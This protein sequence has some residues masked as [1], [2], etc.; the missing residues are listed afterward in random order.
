[1]PLLLFRALI[2]CLACS[3]ILAAQEQ[4]N[5]AVAGKPRPRLGVAL[6]GGNALGLAHIGILRYFEE[7]HIPIDYIT[8]TSMGGLVGG[9]YA[10]GLDAAQLE[11]IVR[12]ANWDDLLSANYRF[13]DEPIV[14]KQEWNRQAGWLTLRFGKRF[15]LPA[16]INPGQALALLLSRHTQAYSN[17][18]TF[19]DLPTPFRC[20]ATDLVTG[21]PFVL[22]RGS[23]PKA[24][25]ATMALPGI[26]TPVNW[27]DKVL[28]DGGITNNLP[29]DE[30][31]KMGADKVIAVVV[32]TGQPSARQFTS[33]TTVLRQTASIAVL[34]NERQQAANAN[35]VIR[36]QLAG[37]TGADYEQSGKIIQQGYLAA[38]AM[39]EQLEPY[40]MHSDAEWEA[41]LAARKQRFQIAP[42]QGPLVAVASPQPAIERNATHELYRKL[43]AAP[44]AEGQLEDVL[45]GVVAATGLPGAYYEWLSDPGQRQGYRVE[46]LERPDQMLLMHPALS[47]SISSGEPGRAAL[48]LGA[49]V[50]P[51]STY[52]SRYLAEF[53]VGYDPGFR[54]E[55]YHPFDGSGYFIA[56]GLMVQ[57]WH[58]SQYQ[59]PIHQTFIRD[60][61]AGSFYAGLGTWRF[62]QFRVGVRAGYDS[63]SEPVT[64]DGVTAESGPFAEPE[65]VFIFNNQ[66][67]GSIPSR[68][69]RLESAAGYSYRA[70]SFPF[71]HNQFTHFQ[72]A[73]KRVSLFARG[74]AD[75]SFGKNLGFFDRFTFG[76]EH[77][78]EAYRYQEFHANTVIAGG[79]G[80]LIHGPAIKSLSTKAILGVWYEPARLDLGSSGWQTHQSAA[81][82]LFFPTPVGALGATVAF[83]ENGKARFRLSLGS[84]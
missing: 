29:V 51:S 49:S 22:G 53:D 65:A 63:Y 79:A 13:F 37:V 5:A 41:Y 11:T 33:L 15:A 32:E 69:T 31:R 57:R 14:E 77:A 82:G 1:M 60:R 74:Q 36:V 7:R 43:G 59:G 56:H 16:G 62:T 8:G 84:F 26:F 73:G 4:P 80:V 20:V 34:Q 58:N 78:L 25:R 10:T 54:G 83:N 24:L 70:R 50:I 19:D 61:F 30:V 75:T 27:G 21:T 6:G 81:T 18:A 38:N 72:P 12:D 71:F 47:F 48:N 42:D 3:C 40:A 39:S 2:L 76:G 55:Y 66:D 64:L 46:F 68:G 28:I 9:F 35:L 52:K 45:A 67:S 44:V 23:L 17:L